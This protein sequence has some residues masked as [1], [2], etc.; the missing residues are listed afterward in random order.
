MKIQKPTKGRVV[1]FTAPEP[2]G[3]AGPGA[4]P[5]RYAG[6]IVET[7]ADGAVDIFTMGSNSTYHQHNN[8]DGVG[9]TTGSWRYPPR[10]ADEIDV[11][12]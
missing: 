7:H 3:P 6:I 1:E 4:K 12:A 9:G 2:A 8:L 11:A 10:C 5:A